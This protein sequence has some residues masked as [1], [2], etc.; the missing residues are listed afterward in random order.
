MFSF[1]NVGFVECQFSKAF[2][3]VIQSSVSEIFFGYI[4]HNF[5]IPPPNFRYIL[6]K[7]LKDN[8]KIY[9]IYLPNSLTVET[10]II[11]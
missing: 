11:R 8:I 3:Y 6:M 5:W 2:F 4:F 10:S 1:E 7:M 9:A